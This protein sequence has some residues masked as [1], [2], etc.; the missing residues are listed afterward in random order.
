[1]HYNL[2]E[3]IRIRSASH[4]FEGKV[5]NVGSSCALDADAIDQLSQGDPKI[6]ELLQAALVPVSMIVGPNGEQLADA[7]IGGE[8]MVVAEIDIAHSIE[9][10]NGPT[11]LSAA[12][13]DLT[14]FTW[15]LIPRLIALCGSETRG[16]A[17]NSRLTSRPQIPQDEII[18]RSCPHQ[19]LSRSPD[20]RFSQEERDSDDGRYL[21]FLRR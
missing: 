1:M 15:N 4:A 17:T 9:H 8:G 6:R 19:T 13:I 14:F 18:L 21:F 11:T 7:V 3:A 2:T 5:F 12:T 10:K 16:V 20:V